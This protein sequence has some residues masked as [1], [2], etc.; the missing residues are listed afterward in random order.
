MKTNHLFFN[1]APYL[2]VTKTDNQGD[3]LPMNLQS[4]EICN[5]KGG[6]FIAGDTRVNE[7]TALAAMH[8]VWM[9]LHNYFAREIE[10]LGTQNPYLFHFKC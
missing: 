5:R 2:A 7:N 1:L 6:C 3:L 10:R 8:T 4:D 9:R